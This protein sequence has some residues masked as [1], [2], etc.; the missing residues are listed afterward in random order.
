MFCFSWGVLVYREEYY[1]AIKKGKNSSASPIFLF[2]EISQTEDHDSEQSKARRKNTYM[3]RSA[4]PSSLMEEQEMGAAPATAP[5]PA[6]PAAAGAA[7]PAAPA[8]ADGGGW[9]S[10]WGCSI[11]PCDVVSSSQS[12]LVALC[13]HLV[14]PSGGL[15]C[16]Q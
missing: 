6:E 15:R 8:P 5:A 14:L 7:D 10:I 11:E 9:R 13:W 1:R 16:Q 12:P 3:R 4:Q 2:F